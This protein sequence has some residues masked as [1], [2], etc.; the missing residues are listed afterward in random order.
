MHSWKFSTNSKQ[1]CLATATTVHPTHDIYFIPNFFVYKSYV[2]KSNNINIIAIICTYASGVMNNGFQFPLQ[3]NKFSQAQWHQRE[4]Y[5]LL[6]TILMITYLFVS[7]YA[8]LTCLVNQI[9]K[10]RCN[11]YWRLN[12][13]CA[14]W[15]NI[16]VPVR[17][18]TIRRIQQNFKSIR[19]TEM[20]NVLPRNLF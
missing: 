14:W 3:W 19:I 12:Y 16:F 6:E 4:C 5:A 15:Y 18:K 10:T 8:L 11:N 7:L 13:I 9:N 17:P 1:V 20:E 2:L